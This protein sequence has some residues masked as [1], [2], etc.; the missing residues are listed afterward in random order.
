[1]DRPKI[2]EGLKPM[3]KEEEWL[4]NPYFPEQTIMIG[5]TFSDKAKEKLKDILMD[6]ID[7]F[8]WQHSD[9][10]GISRDLAEH[11]LNTYRASRPVRQ[12]RR[13][14][15]PEQRRVACEESKKLL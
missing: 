9:M 1:M 14:M 13:A 4:L 5:G 2:G 3:Q 7:V 8:A 11:K 6:N 10:T 15:D 12:K